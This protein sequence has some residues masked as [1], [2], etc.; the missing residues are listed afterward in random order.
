MNHSNKT[1]ELGREKNQRNALIRSL[2]RSLII[3]GK[4]QTTE[5]RAKVIKP[6]VEKM[7]TKAKVPS[8][9]VERMLTSAIGEVSAHKIIKEIA[10]KYLE[11]KGGYLRIIKMA[12]RLSDSARM[13]QIEFV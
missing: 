6:R 8:I 9:S 13:A 12:P 7:I 5:T 11:R 2:I 1:K 4:I 10:P 3:E